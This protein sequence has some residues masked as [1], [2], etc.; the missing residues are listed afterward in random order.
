MKEKIKGISAAMV[1]GIRIFLKNSGK[2]P[3]N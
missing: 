3:D 2:I 1:I